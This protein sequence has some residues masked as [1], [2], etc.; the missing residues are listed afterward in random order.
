MTGV[1]GAPA[2]WLCRQRGCAGSVVAPETKARHCER[3]EA[4]LVDTLACQLRLLPRR[5][6][7]MTYGAVCVKVCDRDEFPNAVIASAAK[8]P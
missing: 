2:V 3:S 5:L 7:A 8:Q 4:T 1:V 6:V